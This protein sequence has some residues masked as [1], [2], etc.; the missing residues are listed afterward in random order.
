M[1]TELS[2]LDSDDRSVSAEVFLKVI[3][4]EMAVQLEYFDWSVLGYHTIAH[5]KSI[6]PL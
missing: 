6:K 3:F 2:V 4:Y 5:F 1:K